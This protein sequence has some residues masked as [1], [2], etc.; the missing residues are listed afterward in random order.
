MDSRIGNFA[1]LGAHIFEISEAAAK[2]P[3]AEGAMGDAADLKDGNAEAGEKPILGFTLVYIWGWG[4]LLALKRQNKNKEK[5]RNAKQ[6]TA[7]SKKEKAVNCVSWRSF[8]F[9]R[10]SIFV[11]NIIPFSDL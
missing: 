3:I 5:K 1:N 6:E 8:Y 7:L 2:Q 4:I 11:I 9:T 10:L